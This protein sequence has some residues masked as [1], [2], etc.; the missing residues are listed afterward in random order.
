MPQFKNKQT[1]EIISV[2][3]ARF[4]LDGTVSDVS[5]KHDLSQYE[6]YSDEPIDYTSIRA[7]KGF[8]DGNGIR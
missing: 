4:Y 7:T 5:G 6:Y 2:Q 1:G 3:R 8:K